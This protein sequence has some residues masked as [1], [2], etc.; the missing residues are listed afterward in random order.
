LDDG[1]VGNL[2]QALGIAESIDAPHSRVVTL[3]R[4]RS[5]SLLDWLPVPQ[6]FSDLPGPPYPQLV[7]AAGWRASRVSCWLKRQ[8]PR[9]FVIQILRP[10]HPWADYDVILLP[11]HDRPRPRDNV[12]ITT[13]AVNRVKPKKLLLAAEPWRARLRRCPPP[14]VAVLI[15]G[16]S[17]HAPF[18]QAEAAQLAKEML[19]AA[20]AHGQSLLVSTSARTGVDLTAYLRDAF[21]QQRE[22][23]VHF[24]HPDP[25][26]KPENPYFAYL[27]LADAVVVT[28]DSI[29]MVS[30]AATAGKPVYVWA[31]D[32]NPLLLAPK[33]RRLLDI[34]TIQK[35][36]RLWDGD[37]T[38]HPPPHGLMDTQLAMAFI[39]EKLELRKLD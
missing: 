22:V 31:P 20:K 39:R 30:E 21:T 18:G 33:A 26:T 11:A 35:R 29:S 8:D 4:R 13:G 12:Y 3:H 15:G 6:V 5:H 37:L 38:L 19:G 7:V 23:P 1:R 27:A 36:A 14:R 24:W 28:G 32:R 2:N 10:A 9:M 34:L 16:A 25:V 17:R